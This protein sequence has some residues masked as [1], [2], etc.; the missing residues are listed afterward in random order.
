MAGSCI[1]VPSMEMVAATPQA[2]A[3]LP[4]EKTHGGVREGIR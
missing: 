4:G 1:D 3:S 2:H